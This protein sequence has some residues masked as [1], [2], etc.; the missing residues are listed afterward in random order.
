MRKFFHLALFVVLWIG[1]AAS[2]TAVVTR[3]VNVRSGPSTDNPPITKLLPGAHLELLSPNATGGYYHVRTEDSTAG[4][5]WGR[6][7][8][9]SSSEAPPSTATG[10][11]ATASSTTTAFAANPPLPLLSKGHPVDWWFVFKF[12]SAK[13]PGCGATAAPSCPF[14]GSVQSYPASSQ[15]F[16]Y[17][18]SEDRVLH[19]GSDCVG[20]STDDPVGASFDEVYNG[21][22]YYLVWNDQFYQDP[23]IHG[24]SGNSCSAPWG[25]SKGM[26]A[27][28]DAGDGFVLQVTTPSWPASG[29]KLH[30]RQSD[31]NTLGCIA[32]D[33]DIQVS[34]HFFALRLSKDDVIKVLRALGNASVVTD[35]ANP[36][37]VKLGGPADIQALAKT[38]GKKSASQS[39]TKDVLSTGVVLISKPSNLHVP[40]WQFVSAVLGG[41]PLRTATWWASPKIDST[42]TSSTITCWDNTLGQAGAVAV[43]TTGQWNGKTFALVG[44]PGY[45][46]NH[47]K[48]AVS[49][50]PEHPLSV[51]GDMNQQGALT[52]SSCSRS[53][54]GRGGLF[55]V[56]NDSTLTQSLADL[57]QGDTAPTAP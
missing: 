11:T 31:G 36:Q 55:Y 18:S 52:G 20:D 45:D 48:F 19:K 23:P 53:Q 8:Q 14:G 24:C 15:Q 28:N 35:P 6:N 47:A 16:V 25:H 44:G 34:Q 32:G 51:F 12:N 7:I 9:I 40:P 42:N 3:N 54:N 39:S 1:V 4:Y 27:W 30:P 21:S 56:I 38:V 22:Y 29:S 41:I 33:N 57:L 10:S 5:V 2:Q 49:T 17:A 37:I 13:F 43:A 26:L 50:S 46:S